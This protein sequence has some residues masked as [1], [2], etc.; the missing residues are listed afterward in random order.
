MGSHQRLCCDE[1]RERTAPNSKLLEGAWRSPAQKTLCSLK[2][3]F[4]L[5]ADRAQARGMAAIATPRR[6]AL[7][8]PAGLP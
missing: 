1:K 7:L 3:V 4:K 6:L 8:Q 5:A 2:G